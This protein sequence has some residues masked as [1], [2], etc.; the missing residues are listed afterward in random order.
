MSDGIK[1]I[2]QFIC[3]ALMTLLGILVLAYDEMFVLFCAL[4]LVVYGVGAFLSW[5][6]HRKTGTASKGSFWIAV[7]AFAAGVAIF[8]GGSFLEFTAWIIMLILGICFISV[9]I[10]EVI[11]AVIYRKAMT[12]VDLGVQAPGSMA[13]II[14]GGI[15]VGFGI[16][17][18]F[19]PLFAM[20]L[21]GFILAVAMILGGIRTIVVA[22]STGAIS[23][24]EGKA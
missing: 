1:R 21:T 4:A 9:G 7:A 16:F 8:V 15:V 10:L 11:G 24:K 19:A 18:I 13:A 6:V 20:Q 14:T 5:T 22:F 2:L 23:R 3:G 17:M 12:S